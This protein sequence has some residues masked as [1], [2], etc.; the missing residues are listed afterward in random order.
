[1]TAQML[2]DNGNGTILSNTVLLNTLNVVPQGVALDGS[3]CKLNMVS[4]FED[5]G[6]KQEIWHGYYKHKLGFLKI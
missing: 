2:A 5:R 6:S 4:E 3:I 1:M